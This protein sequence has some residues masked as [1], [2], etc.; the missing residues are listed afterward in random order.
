MKPFLSF[1]AVVMLC[2]SVQ[3]QKFSDY[4]NTS[5]L[6]SGDIF[7]FSR[8]GTGTYSID[9][10]QPISAWGLGSAAFTASSAY[11]AAG[12]A[13]NAT[14][15]IRPL[16]G[17]AAFINTNTLQNFASNSAF[18]S[19]LAQI[20]TTSN[21][22]EQEIIS[23]G[24]TA[25]AATNISKSI[26]DTSS[27]LLYSTL[28]TA[29]ADKATTLNVAG[30][31]GQITFAGGAQDLSG[32]RTWTGSL[33]GTL[34]APGSITATTFFGLDQ[35]QVITNAANHSLNWSNTTYGGVL[36]LTTNG[37]FSI[38]GVPLI[39]ASSLGANHHTGT[40]S[41]TNLINQ[42]DFTGL[43]NSV[44]HTNYG[45]ATN[46]T[47]TIDGNNHTGTITNGPDVWLTPSIGGAVSGSWSWEVNTN[48]AIH[49]NCSARWLAGS[50]AVSAGVFSITNGEFDAS[51]Y[52]A[53]N[54][55]HVKVAIG[56]N[57]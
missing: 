29:K 2:F 8:H 36:T 20:N 31:S 50:N 37:V 54:F 23:G 56:E 51:F 52:G 17:L 14:N 39:G 40:D 53:T 6:Q 38:N 18:A 27:N 32:N 16:S 49:W 46:I 28:N 30:T 34:V 45:T 42:E 12:T 33:P 3:A 11:D 44:A 26:S 35:W 13:L 15:G 19:A 21:L 9:L 25:A 43:T 24:V 5:S 57:Q 55:P 22:L 41:G 48:I 7:L 1:F 10:S 47:F 4:P